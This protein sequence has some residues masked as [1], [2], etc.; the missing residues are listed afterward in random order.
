[1]PYVV[2]A[3]R[4][5]DLALVYADPSRAREEL[6]WTAEKTVDDMCRDSWHFIETRTAE[7]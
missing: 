2:G 7:Q 5:G 1:V 6:H 4:D 3:R